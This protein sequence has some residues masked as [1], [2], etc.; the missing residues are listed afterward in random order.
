MKHS[1]FQGWGGEFETDQPKGLKG[2]MQRVRK[3][4]RDRDLG[5]QMKKAF[6]TVGHQLC[7]M[8]VEFEVKFD[9]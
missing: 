7:H 5:N 4:P 3:S 1:E 2:V 8:L 9:H 6:Q